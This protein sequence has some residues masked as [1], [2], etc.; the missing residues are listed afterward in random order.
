MDF[1]LS[2]SQSIVDSS[3]LVDFSSIAT[4][5]SHC[6]FGAEQDVT[7]L[8]KRLVDADRLESSNMMRLY[9]SSVPAVS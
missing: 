1:A 2:F 9:L 4:S 7:N 3:S 5:R 8:K 6:S